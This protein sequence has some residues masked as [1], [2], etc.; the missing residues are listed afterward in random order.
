M[1]LLLI[2]LLNSKAVKFFF[3][4]E[5]ELKNYKHVLVRLTLQTTVRFL[6]V[7][8]LRQIRKAS[9][10]IFKT[11]LAHSPPVHN[12]RHETRNFIKIRNFNC[13]KLKFTFQNFSN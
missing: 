11:F 12:N 5:Y 13:P 2:V 6:A 1:V 3:Y 10:K 8:P 7:K 4:Y 9:F